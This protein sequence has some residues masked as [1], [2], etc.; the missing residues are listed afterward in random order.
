M[1]S[2][3]GG[4]ALPRLAAISQCWRCASIT[5]LLVCAVV[6]MP[7][8]VGAQTAPAKPT[9]FTVVDG[10]KEIGLRWTGPDDATIT[11]WQYKY[12]LNADI[13]YGEWMDM[14]GS[15]PNTRR[16]IVTGLANNKFYDF[17][18]R[19]VNDTG[20]SPPTSENTGESYG[21]SP[22]KPTGLQ[23]APGSG[24][25][26][27]TWDEADYISIQIWD[28]RQKES[29][30]SYGSWDP[31]PSS[32]AYTTTHIV[33]GLENGTEYTFQV[34]SYNSFGF[35]PIS[36][37]VSTTP[38]VTAPEKPTGFS[39]EPGNR[40]AT[41]TWDDPDDDTIAKWQYAYK[42]TAGYGDWT[43]IAESGAT[44]VR[45]VVSTLANDTLYTFKIR[46]VNNVGGGA[47]SD[48]VSTTPTARAPDKPTGLAVLT[49]DGQIT[50]SWTDP[51]D[52]SILKWQYAYKT[53]GDYGRW[54]DIPGSGAITTS[55][56]VGSLTNGTTYT[57]RIRAV[58]DV[59]D[60]PESDE[61]SAT[62]LSVPAKPAGFTVTAGDA[63]VVLEWNDPMNASIAGWQYSWKTA[64]DY[65]E[66]IDISGSG[67]QTTEHTV[68]GLTNDVEHVFRIRAVNDSGNGAE[69]EGV[70]ATPIPVPAKPAGFRIE[71][72]NTQ[73]RLLWTDPGNSSIAGWQ[74][75]L[76]TT[77]DYGA[78][79]D[80]PGSGATTVRY[81]VTGLTNGTAYTFRIHAVNGSGAGLQSDEVSAT[82]QFAAPAKPTGFRAE[83]GNGQVVLTWNDPDDSSI[84]DWQYNYKT[85]GGDYM[86]HW[87]SIP[88]SGAKT[89]RY[90]VMSLDNGTTYV[91]KIR[92]VNG[93]NGYESDERTATPQPPPPAKPTGLSATAGDGRV[94]LTWDDPSNATISKWQYAYKTT[95]G[96]GDWTDIDGSIATTTGHTVTG[97]TNGVA[98]TLTIRAV[99]GGGNGEA[100]DEVTVTPVLPPPA[101]PAGFS[102]TPGEAL[103]V[104][105]WDDPSNATISKW[106]Y[107]YKATGGYGDWT[108]VPD[109]TAT[110]TG[111][112]VTGLTNG[113]AH[114]FKVR[115]VNTSGSG[116]A[117]DEAAATP[118]AVPAKPTGFATA[119]GDEQVSLS[120]TDPDNSTITGWQYSYKTTGGYGDWTDV[121]GSIATTTAYI[122][123][124]LTNG[125]AHTF[126]LRAVNASGSG[127]ASDE[128]AAT[129]LAVPAKPAGFAATV[130]DGQVSLSWTDPGNSTIAGWQYSYKTTGGYGDW[131]DI[132][133][134]TATTT[135]HIV[136][137]LT[138]GT[139]HTF[140]VRAVNASGN[141]AASDEKTAT[142]LAVP[143]K[144]TGFA[145]AAGDG[146]VSLSWTDPGN[147]TITSWQ[148][149]YKTTGG[150]GDWTDIDDSTATTTAHI[151]TGLTN[152]TAHTFKVHAVN[153]SGNGA[154]SDEKTATPLAVPA[155][156]TG[157]ATAAGDGQVS[158]SWTDP[159]NSTI[160]SW[161]YAYGTTG[162]YGDWTDID[163]STATTTAHI[164]TGLTNGTAH[165]FKVHAVNAS[166]NGAASDE[167]T[168]T[169]LAVPA[170]PTGFATAAGDGQVSLSWTDPGN[171]T[172]TSWQYAYNTTGGY[173]DWTDIDDSTATTTAH[174]VTG[175]TNGTAHT[176]SLRAVNASGSG[177]ASDEKTA[178]PLAVPTKPTGF[179]VTA[180]DGQVSL[181]WTDP[182]NSTIAGWQYSY[183]TTG[184]YGDWTDVPDSTAT[185][186][187]HIVTGLTNGT[188][189]TFMVRAVNASGSGAA[190]DEKTATPLAVP[191]KPTGFA[192]AP[193]DGQVSLSWTDPGNSTISG[194]QY[195]Y[196]TTGGY[197]DWTDVPDSTATTTA[198]IVT[199]L[200]NGTAHT[201]RLRAVNAS[202]NGTASDE[203]T[204]TPL[205][206]PAK[207][208]GATPERLSAPSPPPLTARASASRLRW[209]KKEPVTTRPC[210][211]AATAGMACAAWAWSCPAA[212]DRRCRHRPGARISG[213]GDWLGV[214][215]ANIGNSA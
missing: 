4:L 41:L 182:G 160:T 28:Y 121:P 23:V 60:G 57:I 190:S 87:R 207:P 137:G 76:K 212:S 110:T 10:Y 148:Y 65:G 83:A 200:T 195:S 146:Q 151:V 210:R 35:S 63:Q 20:N 163:D 75:S 36:D 183:K 44:T 203:K 14:E 155:K 3:P 161:Q 143:A 56:T 58:N 178:T 91:F 144:P 16:H 205:A 196:K 120:W 72:G 84:E 165:T 194:W 106:Q 55:H 186:T 202:G 113:T 107:A 62:P 169:P 9:G 130:G 85:P 52:A 39:V 67:A 185:T 70:A 177:A 189:H 208:T 133:D 170:K 26:T 66:W 157:F 24:A 127:A 139:D 53:S 206:V 21:F 29:G 198:H 17:T 71:A 181:S 128:A 45:H 154:A 108:D 64:G 109:S 180:G 192:A 100:S 40:K 152:G 188:A 119:A 82:P 197:G 32:G 78:W 201:F 125:T 81:T 46:A 15:G 141:G 214:P 215:V 97:L 193:G 22:N 174:I 43:D 156:P 11:K 74:Y 68:T 19:A 50:L 104:L 173:G 213:Y 5:A 7:G 79:T 102:A 124:G 13:S 8:A 77:G 164:V 92:A 18:I 42:T 34:R 199:E 158:L 204:A 98:H 117:S 112:T 59:G 172:I 89:V 27:L 12:K 80:I 54:T 103:V 93:T 134:S 209:R 191:A 184:G 138:N 147:S 175:L 149:A 99:N 187:A 1:F 31:I 211:C 140:K 136:T 115:A 105:A 61:A 171:S 167:K 118:L 25:I 142:P 101:K 2:K 49:G 88:G 30:G 179:A 132:D 131:T 6:A 135:A 122:V 129:P 33:D 166:G 69:S 168:A 96:Y 162:G 47:E 86:D 48:E 90:A 126:R 38:M 159:G 114:T 153:A 94:A 73:A 95:G 51:S 123:T 37:E 176:F 116:A 111:H 150:Y 145:T